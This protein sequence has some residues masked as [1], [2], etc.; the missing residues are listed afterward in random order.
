[1]SIGVL[2]SSGAGVCDHFGIS[3]FSLNFLGQSSRYNCWN[4]K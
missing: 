4:L 3:V 1:M 2:G